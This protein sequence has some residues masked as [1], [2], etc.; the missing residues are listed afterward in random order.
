MKTN[1]SFYNFLNFDN[2]SKILPRRNKILSEEEN[3][4]QEKI[5][6]YRP[7]LDRRNKRKNSQRDFIN[8]IIHE[9][10]GPL[11]AITGFSCL[12]KEGLKNFKSIEDCLDYVG[13]IE[14]AAIDL[15]DFIKDLLEVDSIDKCSFSVNLNKKINI[16]DIVKRSIRLNYNFSIKK[17]ITIKT[18]ISEDLLPINLDEKRMKQIFFNLISNA[19]KY[20][21][22][23]T[24]IKI[25]VKNILINQ[26]DLLQVIIA[27]NGFGMDKCQL[28]TAF[29]KYE[30]I[31]N[32]NS[33]FVDSFGFGLSIVR[34]LVELQNGKILVK[35]VVNKGSEFILEF[36]YS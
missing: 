35:S 4:E 17:N 12:I 15:N 27:D 6:F 23:G 14:K 19:I 22:K 2:L 1:H 21:P 3:I 26:Q 7:L 34:E 11:N 29:R 10:R 28:R 31:K 33:E 20:S 36:P 5:Y 30:A 24:E 25:C 13:E 8:S 32:S 9:L 16:T 18:E